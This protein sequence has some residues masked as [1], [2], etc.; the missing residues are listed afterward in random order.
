MVA[1][2]F[3]VER[4]AGTTH[5][6]P[7]ARLIVV[8]RERHCH[9]LTFDFVVWRNM[10]DGVFDV[11]AERK[12]RRRAMREPTRTNKQPKWSDTID[13]ILIIKFDGRSCML[14]FAIDLHISVC[15]EVNKSTHY[16]SD[17]T[18]YPLKHTEALRSATVF[19]RTSSTYASAQT[20]FIW[21]CFRLW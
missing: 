15:N 4:A 17:Q 7:Y 10:I 5:G 19:S 14:C 6:I 2:S 18:R 20:M 21:M 9:N 1:R 16:Q 13:M 8:Q 12:Y 11:A 3:A